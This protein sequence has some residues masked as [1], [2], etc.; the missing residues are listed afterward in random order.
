VFFLMMSLAPTAIKF[1]INGFYRVVLPSSSNTTTFE[2]L[3]ASSTISI[4]KN[5]TEII[6]CIKNGLKTSVVLGS[7]LKP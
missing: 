7:A 4:I 1:E 6:K 3:S 5:T 2:S